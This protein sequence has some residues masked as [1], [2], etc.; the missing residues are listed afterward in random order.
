[1]SKQSHSRRGFVK[2]A[3]L[4]V[5]GTLGSALVPELAVAQA[6]TRATAAPDTASKAV[7]FRQALTNPQGLVL[8]VVNSVLM[9]RLCEMEGFQA[10]FM[11]GS[12]FA[13]QYGL[14]NNSLGTL[15]EV[16]TYMNQVVEN[17]NLPMLVDAEDGGGS[18]V[19]VYRVVQGFERAGAACIMIEDAVDPSTHF[20]GKG[21]P[22]ATA[23]QMANRV[24]AA[25]DARKD[26][27]VM[28]LVRSDAPTK[29]YPEQHTLDLASA[30][31]DAG[32]DA[33][34]FAGFTLDQ[35]QKAKALLKKPL[36]VGS[37]GPASEWKSK[38]V[39]MAYTHVENVGI[40]AIYMA[41]KELKTTGRFAE[42]AK[43]QLPADI[44]ARLIDQEGWRARAK[45]YGVMK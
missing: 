2:R 14:P 21:A 43:M 4:A 9:A 5:G 3:G 11:G 16:M 24:K 15:T 38:G 18:P 22:M 6:Q 31:S 45:K 12:G 7:R 44:N 30:C 17:T 8:P 35:Q 42:T 26:P 34:Y 1:M 20:N 36:M 13:A 19:I 41:L 23:E 27:N 39:D 40:G 10:G 25:V 29:G 33:F 28:I 32:A 37:N